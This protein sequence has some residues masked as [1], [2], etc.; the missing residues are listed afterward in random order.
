V[1]NP[2]DIDPYIRVY[3]GA[4][5]PELCQR[6]IETF[7]ADPVVPSPGRSSGGYLPEVSIRSVTMIGE[8][9]DTPD[10]LAL[11]GEIDAEIF[12]A[13]RVSW[14]R[15][16]HDAPTGSYLA[17][18]NR[19]EDSGYHIQ[20]YDAGKGYFRQ[21]IDSSAF[22]LA[23]RVA[24]AVIYLNTVGEGGGTRFPL[25]DLTVGCVQGRILWFPA[26]WT[27]EHEGTMPI[28]DHKWSISTFLCHRGHKL[29]CKGGPAYNAIVEAI[30]TC[31]E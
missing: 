30:G 12:A 20:K 6:I 11:W 27:Y 10:G 24:A 2:S 17:G 23:F 9:M 16:L 22:T 3:D 5:S 14:E 28:S 25:H 8:R 4:L 18:V 19:I 7:E 31:D 1:Q 13:L 21:H 29:L 26:T 15:Y